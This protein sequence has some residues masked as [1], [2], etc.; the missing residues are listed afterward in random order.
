MDGTPGELRRITYSHG[1]N[2][3]PQYSP[4]GQW[5]VFTS[6]RMGLNDEQPLVNI[7]I[8]S[9]QAYAD[10]YAYRLK[11]GTLIRLTNNKWEDGLAYWA[12]PTG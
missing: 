8:F 2:A 11:D 1:Q 10:L 12:P 7:P 3:H 5:L 6:E 9:P 4:D